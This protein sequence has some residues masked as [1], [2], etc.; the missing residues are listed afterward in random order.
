MTLGN[1]CVPDTANRQGGGKRGACV[2]AVV[3]AE[4]QKL[5]AG[6]A[7]QLEATLVEPPTGRVADEV[8]V[9]ARGREQVL[10]SAIDM[11]TARLRG[12]L[13]ESLASIAHM[14]PPLAQYT[15]SSLEALQL[16]ELGNRARNANDVA[17]AERCYREALE[18]DPRFAAARSSLGLILI[19]FL[20]RPDEGRKMLAQALQEEGHVSQREYLGLRA[21]NKQFV[22]MDLPGAL[23]DYRFISDLYPDLVPPYNNSGRILLQMGRLVEAAGMFARAHRVDPRHPVPLWNSYFLSVRRLKDPGQAERAARA[24]VALLPDNAGALHALGWSLIA[25]RR[26]PEA[27][28]RMRA[29]LKLDPAH[30]YA[31]PGPGTGRRRR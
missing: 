18:R 26:F 15:T 28:D 20:D 30:A 1:D 24:L 13:G 22:T 8:S 3:A 27:E 23:E 9:T 17:K 29:V 25:E 19:Q 5:R 14:A 4:N 2:C 31:L 7:Y 12:H 16:L 10:L 21:V 6:E 11:L